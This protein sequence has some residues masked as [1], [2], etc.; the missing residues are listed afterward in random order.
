[1]A[2][3]YGAPIAY[4]FAQRFP[5]S[6]EKLVLAGVMADVP[7][8]VRASILRTLTFL[9]DERMTDFARE[10]VDGLLCTDPAKPVERRAAARRLL[11]RQFA[12]MGPAGRLRYCYNVRRLLEHATLDLNNAPEMP[13]L[14]FTGEHD[15]YTRPEACQAIAEWCDEAVF[16]TIRRADH[17]FHLERFDATLALVSWFLLGTALRQED[18][19]ELERHTRCRRTPSETATWAP[20]PLV[21]ASERV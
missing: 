8:E 10:V 20:Q 18:Y 15:V 4:R 11:I 2:A 13:V 17:L 9:G 5:G 19:T 7:A 1:M 14:V 21:F 12:R 6:V 16:T 3:S